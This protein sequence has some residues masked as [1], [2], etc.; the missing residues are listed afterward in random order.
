MVFKK[1]NSKYWRYRFE[2]NGAEVNKSTKQ[3]NKQVAIQMESAHR[4]RLAKAEVGIVAKPPVP[5]VADFSERFL[6]HVRDEMAD[7]PAT[8]YFYE[9]R[10]AAL[11]K[12]KVLNQ[13][14]LDSITSEHISGY[15]GRMRKQGFKV[16]TINRNL[17]TLRKMTKLLAEWDEIPCRKVRLLDGEMGRDRVVT[18][19]EEAA[20]LATAEQLARQVS[21]T[22][23]D[24]GCRPNEVHRL[25]WPQ[26]DNRARTLAIWRGKGSGSRRTIDV[27]PRLAELLDSLPR[28]SF[29]VF[30]APTKTGHINADSYKLQHKKAFRA[31][32]EAGTPIPYFVT[33]SLRH[34]AIT[35]LAETGIDAP[36]L[37][38]WAGHKSLQTTMRY[39]HMAAD[40]IRKRIRE[41]RQKV[42]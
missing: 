33:Y 11:L 28:T 10:T 8:V 13:L 17:A 38:Y 14:P 42:C 34:T 23:I 22:I 16:A 1:G 29:Y 25:S 2:F 32:K 12:D 4:T 39:V 26:Y 5:M 36:A 40:A 37:Q 35:R 24:S 18:I 21:I 31:L 7:R 19:E 6:T 9:Q 41:A 27:T 30:P 3:T 20:Y 15:A